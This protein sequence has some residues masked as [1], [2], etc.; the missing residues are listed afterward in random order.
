MIL[1]VNGLRFVETASIREVACFK[2]NESPKLFKILGDLMSKR[3]VN[4]RFFGY[5]IP[6]AIL[7]KPT[8]KLVKNVLRHYSNYVAQC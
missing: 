2:Q 6:H 3:P 4:G 5:N 1:G 8:K 7:N